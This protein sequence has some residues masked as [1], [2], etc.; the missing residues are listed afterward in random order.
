MPECYL[1]QRAIRVYLYQG[2]ASLQAAHY[3]SDRGYYTIPSR[4]ILGCPEPFSLHML[5]ETAHAK[6]P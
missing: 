6:R 5:S 4:S 3:A 2:M 1:P